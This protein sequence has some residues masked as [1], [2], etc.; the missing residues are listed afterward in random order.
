MGCSPYYSARG[1]SEQR[2]ARAEHRNCGRGAPDTSSG[3]PPSLDPLPSKIR[4]THAG[5]RLSSLYPPA[6]NPQV[7][8]EGRWQ[9]ELIGS[10]T[11]GRRRRPPWEQDGGPRSRLSHPSSSRRH[12]RVQ[13]RAN[14]GAGPRKGIPVARLGSAQVRTG[15]PLL[16]PHR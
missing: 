7:V 13:Q 11:R 16:V 9:S 14:G 8:V 1:R 10:S 4:R 12:R 3:V 2:C 6:P 5:R 15:H